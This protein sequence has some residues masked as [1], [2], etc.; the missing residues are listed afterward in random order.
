MVEYDHQVA[1]GIA[2]SALGRYGIDPS[3]ITAIAEDTSHNPLKVETTGGKTYFVKVVDAN[4]TFGDRFTVGDY[5]TRLTATEELRAAGLSVPGLIRTNSRHKHATIRRPSGLYAVVEVQE[6]VPGEGYTGKTG[7]AEIF[8]AT[9]GVAHTVIKEI[10]TKSIKR[11]RDAGVVST[12][13]NAKGRVSELVD[14]WDSDLTALNDDQIP[15][16]LRAYVT[17]L[18]QR[19][20]GYAKIAI[21]QEGIVKDLPMDVVH[22]GLHQQQILINGNVGTLVDWETIRYG[23]LALDFG[24][25]LDR[26]SVT[27]GARNIKAQLDKP[28]SEFTHD[29]ALAAEFATA[30]A[31]QFPGLDRSGAMAAIH[32]R[33]TWALPKFIDEMIAAAQ[34]GN[35]SNLDK[36]WGFARLRDPARFTDLDQII[37]EL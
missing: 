36:Y 30:Y 34:S 37:K 11:L 19:F 26:A 23:P 12:K 5:R 2:E 17:D 28:L 20:P 4:R 16:N 25:G 15:N 1:V 14:K 3:T 33:N 18:I 9:V 7:Q 6:F 10:T 35:K 22:H 13:N 27:G 24:D 21:A 31:R 32:Q 8:G 29:Q